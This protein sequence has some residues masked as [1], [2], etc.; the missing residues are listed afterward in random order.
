MLSAVASGAQGG[1]V[2]LDSSSGLSWQNPPPNEQ[3]DWNSAVAYCNALSLGGHG[4]GSWHLPSIRELRSLI[5]GC[6]VNELGGPCPL[7]G[8]RAAD[9]FCVLDGCGHCS[10]NGGPGHGGAYWAAEV[11]G[12]LD[13]YWTSTT[14]GRSAQGSAWTVHFDRADFFFQLSVDRRRD[15]SHAVLRSLCAQHPLSLSMSHRS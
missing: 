4:A 10:E 12:P 13:A 2:W 8:T 11:S 5:R 7:S 9:V 14:T 6:P 1:G 3:H 15:H